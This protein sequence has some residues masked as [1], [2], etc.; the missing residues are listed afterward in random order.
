MNLNEAT[1]AALEQLERNL[2]NHPPTSDD[3]IRYMEHIREVA[4]LCGTAIITTCPPSR[5]R[6]LAI[7]NLEQT[8][9][10]AIAAIA[11]NQP[12]GQPPSEG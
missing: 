8:T 2:T 5:E 1:V 7:T 4:K 10:W 12:T 11:R 6:S 3:T 9:M